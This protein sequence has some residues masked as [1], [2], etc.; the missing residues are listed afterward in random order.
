LTSQRWFGQ[1]ELHSLNLCSYL[2]SGSKLV[3]WGVQLTGLANLI[4]AFGSRFQRWLK[5][6]A[7][8]SDAILGKGAV[9]H[10]EGNIFNISGV[11]SRIEVGEYCQI[12]GDLLVFASG[13]SIQM[14]QWSYVGPR[15]T[16]WS[17][18]Q[19]GVQIGERVLISMDVH[20]HDTNSHSLD[21]EKRFS[22]TKTIITS[23]HVIDGSDIKSAPIKIG[24]DVWIGFGAVIHKGVT[25]GDRA[26]I[27]AGTV[28]TEDVPA[29]SIVRNNSRNGQT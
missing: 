9:V 29:D 22:Q 8:R 15:S 3:N 20:I 1:A 12:R 7:G 24:N 11:A 28:V 21:H 13:G 14:G 26:I 5:T 6:S 19:P 18:G 23:G 27:G 16:I 10:A 25:I 2:L 4:L 17:S